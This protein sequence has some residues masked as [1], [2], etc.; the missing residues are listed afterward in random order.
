MVDVGVRFTLRDNC[1]PNPQ[2]FLQI[3]SDEPARSAKGHGG[4][5]SAPDAKIIA[6]RRVLLRAERSE[7]GDGRVYV[8]TLTARD[9]SGNAVAATSEVKVNVSPGR[10]AVDSGQFY[11]PTLINE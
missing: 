1:D 4:S 10:E 11:D 8:L 7:D 2:V 9:S 6:D 3:T 5:Q